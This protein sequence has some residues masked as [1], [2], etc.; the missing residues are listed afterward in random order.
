MSF[1]RLQLSGTQGRLRAGRKSPRML[2]RGS[3]AV[4]AKVGGSAISNVVIYRI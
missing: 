1:P 2:L 4:L 3:V